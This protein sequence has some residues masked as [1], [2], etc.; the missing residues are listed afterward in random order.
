MKTRR[1]NN[2][3]SLTLSL[4]A[5]LLCAAMLVGSTMAWFTDNASTAVNKIESGT[6]KIDL[7]NEDGSKSVKKGNFS[8][9]AFKNVNGETDIL[10]EPGATFALEPVKVVNS[11][12]LALTF[13]LLING[14]VGE[15]ATKLAE[16]LDVMV[17]VGD[18]T[19]FTNI[20]TLSS[21]IADPDGAAH[22]N[23]VPAGAVSDGAAE[24]TIGETPLY[25][26]ALH[27]QE[28]ANNDYQGLSIDGLT[29]TVMAAQYTY[30]YDSTS[31][32]YDAGAEFDKLTSVPKN[33]NM[34]QADLQT[35]L[36]AGEG[37]IINF[38]GSTLVPDEKPGYAAYYP[39]LPANNSTIAN[40]NFAGSTYGLKMQ[41]DITFE[42]CTFTGTYAPNISDSVGTPGFQAG[43]VTFKNCTF[44]GFMS[45]A[46]DCVTS[47]EF[48]NCE[49]GNKTVMNS[50]QDVTFVDCTFDN[51][52]A[53]DDE[54]DAE[55]TWTFT[56]CTGLNEANLNATGSYQ[57]VTIVKN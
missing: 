29:L 17:K 51:A 39:A 48:I 40:L 18:A 27:M 33:D 50:Y 45:F 32:Q 26:I 11:G 49:F 9:I 28:D 20:G 6:L 4:L 25:T 31:N 16:V 47:A 37:G 41:G 1:K 3:R 8:Q 10:W 23:I 44:Q 24:T 30:E 55:Q 21:L 35:A 5:M 38:G 15:D 54:L 52:F 46:A 13:K 14:V 53:I 7:V 43:K 34:L 42:N 2:K 19:T 57:T 36:N 22:G 56:N 12:N